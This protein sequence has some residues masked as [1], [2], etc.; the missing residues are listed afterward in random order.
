[1]VLFSDD[2]V[3]GTPGGYVK[4]IDRVVRNGLG[5]RGMLVG[6]AK[7]NRDR[8]GPIGRAMRQLFY[9]NCSERRRGGK[10]P[11]RRKRAAPGRSDRGV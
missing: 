10:A 5:D 1:M 2:W 6:K 8:R 11:S 7:T 3:M 9:V 4:I